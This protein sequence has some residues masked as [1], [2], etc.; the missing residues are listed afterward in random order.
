MQSR[1][2]AVK[3]N[4]LPTPKEIDVNFLHIT[5]IKAAVIFA[6]VLIFSCYPLFAHKFISINDLLNHLARSWILLHLKDTPAFHQEYA[7]NW[8]LLPDLAFDLYSNALGRVLPLPWVGKSFVALSFALLLS[9]T[10]V[11]HY[12]LYRRGSV[13]PFAAAL[14]LYSRPLAIGVVDFLFA[15]GLY[16]HVTALWIRLREKSWPWRAGAAAAGAVVI[17]F[18]HLF[19]VGLL[20]VTLTGYEIGRGLQRRLKLAEIVR[21][22]LVAA[23]PFVVPA[24]I[25]LLWAPHSAASFVVV[26]RGFSGRLIAFAAPLLYRPMLEAAGLAVLAGLVAW[27]AARG[28]VRVAPGIALAL[29]LLFIVQLAM[30]DKLLTAEGADHRIPIAWY[31]LAVGALDIVAETR[32]TAGLVVVAVSLLL[33]GRIALVEARWN[34]DDRIYA[35]IQEGLRKLPPGAMVALGFPPD[36]FD[37]SSRPGIAAF[38]LPTWEIARR[39]GFTQ[40][41]F[42]I[43]T[44]HPLVMRPDYA[45]LARSAVPAAVWTAFDRSRTCPPAPASRNTHTPPPGWARFDAFVILFPDRACLHPIRPMALLYKSP[46]LAV[47]E[48]RSEP[49]KRR[50]RAERGFGAPGD[51]CGTDAPDAMRRDRCTPRPVAASP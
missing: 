14:F 37:Y 29:L 12:A 17:F 25:A 7:P 4:F 48:N 18:A 8:R 11:V 20:A 28:A 40:T 26:Y 41:V 13:W 38:Y 1:L 47:Y 30:P 46:I 36:A 2:H 50:E 23:L 43:P 27:L 42:T 6:I 49:A 45:R 31:F 35:D 24:V 33:V 5:K 3:V 44:Q 9:G 10:S 39:G 51:D 32:R 15:V 19:P 16:L 34:S 22:L 21:D